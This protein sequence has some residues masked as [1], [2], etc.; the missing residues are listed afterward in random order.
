MQT[1]SRKNVKEVLVQKFNIYK[2]TKTLYDIPLS[3]ISFCIIISMSA[4]LNS[5]F[6]ARRYIFTISAMFF[7]STLFREAVF[8]AS[9]IPLLF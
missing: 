4:P 2:H 6:T 5:L 8:W 3:I 9:V 1:T 7:L